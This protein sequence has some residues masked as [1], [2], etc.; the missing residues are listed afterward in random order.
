MASPLTAR[1]PPVTGG[2]SLRM[3]MARTDYDRIGELPHAEYAGGLLI[4][5]PP[6]RHHQRVVR[7]LL[8][9]L[10][11]ACPPGHEVLFERGWRTVE[12]HDRIPDL[13]VSGV[14]ACDDA[15]LIEPPPLLVVEVL[16][17]STRDIDLGDKTAEYSRAGAEW[18][19]VVDPDEPSVVVFR[20]QAGT[21]VEVQHITEPASTVGP[22]I[23]TVDPVA[24]T[25]S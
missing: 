17:P 5:N 24:L 20:L 9:L 3:P 7:R 6:T 4:V 12:G 21:M 23:V 16:S 2:T 22:F 8:E 11:A 19:W 18:Y 13:M 14:G 15:M 10:T 25:C 1:I